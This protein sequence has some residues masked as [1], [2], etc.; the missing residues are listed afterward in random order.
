[1][2]MCYTPL[3]VA[4][5]QQHLV[6]SHCVVPTSVCT[7]NPDASRVTY[8]LNG[9]VVAASQALMDQIKC[10]GPAFIVSGTPDIL[11]AK[12]AKYNFP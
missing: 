7:A 5:S 4:S 8:V 11:T 10:L 9:Q 1:M 12:V 2:S 6:L 3:Q